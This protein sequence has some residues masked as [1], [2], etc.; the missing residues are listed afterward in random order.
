M[1]A[2]Q[3]LQLRKELEDAQNSQ[4]MLI[5]KLITCCKEVG[6]LALLWTYLDECATAQCRTDTTT[7]CFTSRRTGKAGNEIRGRT[8]GRVA[9]FV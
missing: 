5:D 7:I 4:T 3:T 9:R 2:V 1:S 6:T 8:Y